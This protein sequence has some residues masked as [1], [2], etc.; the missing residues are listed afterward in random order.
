M[1]VSKQ[2]E[3]SCVGLL[4][5]ILL[6]FIQLD[7]CSTI[8]VGVVVV[9]LIFNFFIFLLNGLIRVK[10]AV[11][12]GKANFRALFLAFR[13]DNESTLE[14]SVLLLFYGGLSYD[15]YGPGRAFIA[16]LLIKSPYEG[17]TRWREQGRKKPSGPARIAY[18]PHTG[19]LSIA[20]T[21]CELKQLC[22]HI[23]PDFSVKMIDVSEHSE[24]YYPKKKNNGEKEKLGPYAV[25]SGQ[26]FSR[27]ALPLSQ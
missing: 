13:S 22:C 11:R 3:L 9:F 17:R 15:P 24:F 2:N 6:C 7:H 23:N 27:P 4:F 25:T 26:I 21:R 18:G 1:D 10:T 8:V 19:I 12:D 5:S 16:R 14:T 20:R